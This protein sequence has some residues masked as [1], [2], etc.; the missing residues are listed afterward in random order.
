VLEALIAT[1]LVV[2]IGFVGLA[3]CQTVAGVLAASNTARFGANAVEREAEQLQ[4]DAATAFAVFVPSGGVRPEVDFYAKADDGSA[5]F[6][7]YVYDPAART[8]QRWDYDANGTVGV[9][10]VVTG[11]ID[12]GAAYPALMRLTSFRAAALSV[13]ALGDPGINRYSGIAAL[14]EHAPRPYAVHYTAAGSGS[15]GAVGGNGVVAVELADAT[16]SRVIH[17]APGSMPAGFTVT[18]ALVWH[19]IVY[20]VDQSHRFLLGAAGKSHVFINAHV[21]VSYDRWA[22]RIP[23]CDFNLLGNPGGLDAHDPHADYTP[24]QA[25]EQAN[26]I[27]AACRQRHLTPPQIGTAGNATDPDAIHAP[28]PGQTAPPCWTNPGPDGRCWPTDAPSDWVPPS[29]LPSETPPA[30]WCATH[31]RSVAAGGG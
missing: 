22:T 10:D 28:L 30:A 16:T 19:A 18:G 29:P 2:L 26:T 14:F 15:L 25:F 4:A 6:W 12:T 7:R 13:D 21:D 20:R 9:R 11:A 5:L 24:N 3:A 17:L 8:L 27:L 23:W 1:A 31:G